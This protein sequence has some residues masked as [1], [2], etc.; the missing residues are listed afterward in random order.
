MSI[1]TLANYANYLQLP[2]TGPDIPFS[3]VSIDTRTLKPGDLF[4][5]LPGEQFDGHDFLET[6]YQKKAVAALVQYAGH[7]KLPCLQVPDTK[8]AL[9]LLAKYHR[10]QFTIPLIALTGSCGK[11][12]TKEYLRN[13]L[14]QCGKVLAPERSFNNDIGVPLTL[15]QLTKHHDFIVLEMGAN[16]SGEIAWLTHIAQP[17]VAMILNVA[18]AHLEG[19]GSLAQVAAAKSEIFQGLPPDGMAIVDQNFHKIW[20]KHLPA[21]PTLLFGYEG[22]THITAHAISLNSE[23]KASFILVSPKGEVNIQL[24]LPGMHQ[25]DNALAAATA[26]LALD[27]SLENIKQGLESTK[28]VPGRLIVCH[29]YQGATILDDTYNAN[30]RSIEAALKLLVHYQGNHLLVLGD[31]SELG[32]SSPQYHIEI[33]QKARQIGIQ[34]VYGYGPLSKLAV[35]AFGRGG[36][37][38]ENQTDL[39]TALQFQLNKQHIVL[40]KGSRNA[41][42]EKIVSALTKK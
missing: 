40:I 38:F 27:I 20:K 35:Q 10:A 8:K 26:S 28:A 23:G 16:A 14:T 24:P 33:G 9:G 3:S 17:T 4:I 42:M 37:H 19:F 11:T 29:S 39:I 7:N 5:A 21:Q 15:L 36:Q 1:T 25:V 41:K 34:A 2:Y 12:T 6:A 13:I 18:P 30:P 22:K 31:M 32:E